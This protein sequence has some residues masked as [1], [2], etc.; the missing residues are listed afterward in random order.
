M[1]KQIKNGKMSEAGNRI[2]GKEVKNKELEISKTL[3]FLINEKLCVDFHAKYY[4][5]CEILEIHNSML[6]ESTL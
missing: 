3:I 2:N 1:L 5:L 6:T 4:D